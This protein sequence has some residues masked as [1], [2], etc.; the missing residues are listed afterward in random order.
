M[1]ICIDASVFVR[2]LAFEPGSV[3]TIEWLRSQS[4]KEIIGPPFLPVEFGTA[5]LRK[6]TAGHMS[7]AQCNEALVLFDRF[8]VRY[9]WDRGLLQTS[10]NLALE[11][12]QPTIYDTAYLA[13][14]EREKC[15]FWTLDRRF[16]DAVQGRH[17]WVRLLG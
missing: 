5:I 14:A 10:F 8:G 13:I 2:C 16:A 4:E 15:E 6:A 17:T 9:E 1:K 12:R 3:E 7:S 11:L